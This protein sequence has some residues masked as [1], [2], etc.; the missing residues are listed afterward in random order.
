MH[1]FAQRV[2]LIGGFGAPLICLTIAAANSSFAKSHEASKR[3]QNIRIGLIGA[4][5]SGLSLLNAFNKE[6]QR[7]G[8]NNK[9]TNFEVVCFEK[10]AQIGGLWNY[11]WMTG[12]DEQGITV[13]NSQ[14][15]HLWSNGPKE[16]LEMS[17]YPFS[18]HFSGKN[19][20]SFPP[21]PVLKDYI[22]GRVKANELDKKFDI[23]L[24]HNVMNVEQ[25]SANDKFKV[26]YK[27]IKNDKEGTEEFDY[28]V[29]ATGHF[30]TPN[31]VKF[32]GFDIFKGRILHS[33]S[34]RNA[35]EFKGQNILVIG[36]SYSGMQN[37]YKS[38][39]NIKQCT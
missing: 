4:G 9:S 28:L 25:K 23:R 2:G 32:D 27:D 8:Q 12:T 1:T 5:P 22:L 17:D 7:L 13:H 26:I 19:I 18:Q 36:S 24:N 33:H 30:S 3:E 21:R 35:Q 38:C 39:D 37:L 34:F 11:S 6:L 20:S 14:Y 10:Q 31:I 15:S 29:V 16:C